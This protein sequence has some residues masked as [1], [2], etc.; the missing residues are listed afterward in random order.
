MRS[1]E[2]FSKIRRF[3]NT[4]LKSEKKTLKKY[5]EVNFREY[6]ECQNTT[7]S[8]LLQKDL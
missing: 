8:K 2:L 4:S 3:E 6:K 1:I 5:F 7:P